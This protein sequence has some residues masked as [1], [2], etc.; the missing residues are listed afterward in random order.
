MPQL[1][2][3]LARLL[4]ESASLVEIALHRPQ[5]SE[6]ADDGGPQRPGGRYVA[7]QLL[8]PI[9]R[10]RDGRRPVVHGLCELRRDRRL[11][12]RIAGAPRVLQRAFEVLGAGAPAE[13]VEMHFAL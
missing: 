11:L 6:H 4:V 13:S 9:Y 5:S 3:D 12:A 7:Q 8:A 10:C 1:L 2:P